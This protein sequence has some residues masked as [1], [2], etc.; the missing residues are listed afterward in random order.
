MS[1]ITGRCKG[2]PKAFYEASEMEARRLI[3]QFRI[4]YDTNEN[5]DSLNVMGLMQ[6]TK[7]FSGVKRSS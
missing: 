2:S 7:S 6:E 1:G 4:F 3:T 5:K